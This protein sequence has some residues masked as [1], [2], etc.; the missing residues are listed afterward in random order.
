MPGEKQIDVLVAGHICFDVIPEFPQGLGTD[1]G[2]ILVPG[3]LINV[4]KA[5]MST[6]GPV[7]NT[8]LALQRLGQN[9]AFMGKV[10]DDFFGNAILERLKE[11][12]AEKGMSIVPGEATSYTIAIAPPGIDRVFLHNP[13]TNDTFGPEDVNLDIVRQARLFHFGYPP[14]MKRMYENDGTEL[15]EIF[16]RVKKTGVTTSLD[17][18]LPDPSSPS[19]KVNWNTILQGVLPYVDIFLP[20]AEET[21]FM[22]DKEKFFARKK[23]A[24]SKDVLEFFDLSDFSELAAQLLS[25]GAGIVSQKAGWLGFY[26]R[27]A[28]AERLENIGRAGPSR[29]ENWSDRELFEP[30]FHV[31]HVASAT[32]SGDSAIA[33]FLAAY[34]NGESIES[35]IRYACAVAAQN[36]QVLDAVSGIRSW[37]ETTRQ[38]QSGW[39]KIRL[40]FDAPGWRLDEAKQV[41]HGPADR[42]S[43]AS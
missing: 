32:G 6:G 2:Q 17:M 3:K 41:W 27:T 23:Q 24:G 12:G 16:R 20:S 26:I 11:Y 18:S 35:C 43:K 7:S 38:L 5:A 1:L 30:S 29:L 40:P 22:L 31:E 15:V 33:G 8:G 10:G 37:Q 19:G 21:M 4:G 25:Y 13:G 9:V 42:S 28:G 39:P 34:L 36:V 14:L